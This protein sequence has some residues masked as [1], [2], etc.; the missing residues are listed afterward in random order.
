M[1]AAKA[2]SCSDDSCRIRPLCGD[3]PNPDG[4]R[5]SAPVT[6]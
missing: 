6:L 1:I 4:D 2:V 5:M 3:F